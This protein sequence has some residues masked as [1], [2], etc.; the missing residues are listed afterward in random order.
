MNLFGVLIVSELITQLVH[1]NLTSRV[2]ARQQIRLSGIESYIS[3]TLATLHGCRFQ[4]ECLC[5]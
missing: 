2:G 3:G 4:H 1:S 5:V